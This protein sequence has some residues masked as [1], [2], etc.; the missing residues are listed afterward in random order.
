MK[1]VTILAG[2]LCSS[3]GMFALQACSS[4][5]TTTAQTKDAAADGTTPARDGSTDIDGSTFETDGGSPD[6][7]AQ[8]DAAC[9]SSW[10]VAPVTDPSIAVPDGGGGVL[11]HASAIGTQDY[12]CQQ[13]A[14]AGGVYAWVFTGP[15]A[16]LHDCHNG[17]IGHHFASDGGPA[18]PEWMTLD[19]AYVIGAKKAAF[20]P[21]GG[22]TSI[23]WLLIQETATGGMG[24]ITKTQFINRLTTDG[25]VAPS[26]V[27][28]MNSVGTSQKVAYTAD[29]YFYGN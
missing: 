16:E 26:A 10:T 6:D 15:E 5:D 17:L 22:A 9:P 14:D 1:K 27:C 20:T 8:A 24:P 13:T 12:T 18:A 7:A 23:P 29:Y 25:G 11:L 19:N 3:L 4:D 2:A 28:D 21:D